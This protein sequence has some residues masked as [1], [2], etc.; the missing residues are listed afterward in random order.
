MSII[1][2]KI[3][4]ENRSEGFIRYISQQS[5]VCTYIAEQG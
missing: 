5:F 3:D 1:L 2:L 4:D